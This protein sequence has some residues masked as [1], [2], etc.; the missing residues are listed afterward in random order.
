M[1]YR[2]SYT[3]QN[4]MHHFEIFFPT[5]NFFDNTNHICPGIVLKNPVAY[6]SL[7]KLTST[8]DLRMAA[9]QDIVVSI[10]LPQIYL[11][12]LLIRFSTSQIK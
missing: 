4:S 12:T 3:G 11:W 8:S 5:Y 1:P 10:T 7:G 6:K 9:R 2:E